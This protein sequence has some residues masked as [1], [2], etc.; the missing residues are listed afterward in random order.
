M[1]QLPFLAPLNP[2]SNKHTLNYSGFVG[3]GAPAVFNVVS[4]IVA[5]LPFD[6]SYV[7]CCAELDLWNLRVG[8]DWFHI[9]VMVIF[10]VLSD[11][12][13]LTLVILVWYLDQTGVIGN[14]T[15]DASVSLV[16]SN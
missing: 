6:M 2:L 3:P 13:T 14:D 10:V 5:F 7:C 8:G 1:S 11:L 9:A 15:L 4:T 12:L 16:Y